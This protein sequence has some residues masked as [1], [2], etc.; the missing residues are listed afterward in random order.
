MIQFKCVSINK[1]QDSRIVSSHGMIEE[2]TFTLVEDDPPALDVYR[3]GT[4]YG[5]V[6][7]YDE[8]FTMALV[9]PALHGTY[10]IGK[11]YSLVSDVIGHGG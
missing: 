10:E 11:T 4:D 7:L 9:D 8:Q 3:W 1:V 5:R 2:A 6:V